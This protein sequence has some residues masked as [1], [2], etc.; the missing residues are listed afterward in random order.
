MK[1]AI[2]TTGRVTLPSKKM[3]TTA[4]GA[5]LV[6]YQTLVLDASKFKNV[7]L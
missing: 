6:E 4:N 5:A 7:G 2:R 3:R 1:F